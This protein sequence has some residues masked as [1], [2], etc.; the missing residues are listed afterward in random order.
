MALAS[1]VRGK[2][3]GGQQI[4]P[5]D[6]QSLG[7]GLAQSAPSCGFPYVTLDISRITA[8]QRMEVGHEC[9]TC[10]RVET[11][12][13][14]YIEDGATVGI[15]DVAM[16][17]HFAATTTSFE[18]LPTTVLAAPLARRG[19]DEVRYIYVLAVDTGG[20]G[21]DMAQVSFT[22]LFGQSL[23]P[24]AAVWF[25]VDGKYCQDIWR[26]TTARQ[27][28]NPTSMAEIPIYYGR[29]EAPAGLVDTLA[30]NRDTNA[31]QSSSAGN[32]R[33]RLGWSLMMLFAALVAAAML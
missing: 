29:S 18:Q 31:A 6:Y 27:L 7:R 22:A 28:K 2:M 25:P 3:T 10:L 17:T 14:N 24:T 21:L 9:G 32:N 4:T 11:A 1:V 12:P 20:L 5:H 16:A 30:G 8:V 15:P 33:V 13:Q 26:N 19:A 23:S